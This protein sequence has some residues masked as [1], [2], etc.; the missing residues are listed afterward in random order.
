[1]KKY[2]AL[3]LSLFA[4]CLA[5]SAQEVNSA[6]QED[7][8]EATTEEATTSAE[9]ASEVTSD[10][11]S[12]PATAE[13]IWEVAN[14]AYNEGRFATAAENYEAILAQGQH[15]AK[16]YFNLGNAYFKQDD[17]AHAILYYHRALRL[18]PAD[19]DIRHNLEY[20]E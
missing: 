16:V 8:T 20:A 11:A 3:F 4:L 17:L 18:E 10:E 5:V 13:L 1:M 2:I 9:E 19:E 6:S 15:S 7:T 14:A 12:A